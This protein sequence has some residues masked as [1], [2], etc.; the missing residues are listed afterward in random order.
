MI[1]IGT[2]V[3][4]MP[5][6]DYNNRFVGK[7]GIVNKYNNNG[8]GVQ[9]EGAVN[10]ENVYGVYWFREDSLSIIL[11]HDFDYLGIKKVIYS[12]PKTIIIWSDGSKTIASCGKEDTFDPYVGF[13]AAAAKKMF[14]STSK[15]RK[16]VERGFIE[17][18]SL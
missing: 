5:S 16:I 15:I 13:C 14:G 2:K 18:F 1:S 8:V 12:G 6:N 17:R 11:D 3:A 10:G 9:I 4:I 7:V